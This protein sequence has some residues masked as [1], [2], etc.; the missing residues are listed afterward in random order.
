MLGADLVLPG[1]LVRDPRLDYVALGHIHKSQDLN[2]GSHPPVIYPGSIER[3]DFGEAA[4]DKFYVI[5]EIEKQK[6]KVEWRKLA[7]IRPF[8]DRF[9]ELS[10]PEDVTAV[11]MAALPGKMAGSIIRLIVQYPREWETLI[12]EPALRRHTSE[13]FEFHLIKRPQLG[14]RIR[15]P[16]DQTVSSLSPLELLNQY[17]QA[18][19]ADPAAISSLN[20]LAGEIITGGTEETS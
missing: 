13:A 5:A 15:L 11:L 17:W 20:K 3:V 1:S 18:S 14:S 7:G 6:T 19:Q 9:I 8:V 16:A 10:S 4:D 12:D 2:E